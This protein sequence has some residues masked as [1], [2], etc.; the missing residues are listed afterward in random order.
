MFR[1]YCDLTSVQQDTIW[2]MAS[3]DRLVGW[4]IFYGQY[5]IDEDGKVWLLEYDDRSEVEESPSMS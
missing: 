5:D 4:E 3:R 1:R 2:K